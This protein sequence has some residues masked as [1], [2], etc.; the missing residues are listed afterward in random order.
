M[1]PRNAEELE[2][3]PSVVAAR[4]KVHKSFEKLYSFYA[5]KN[6]KTA[7]SSLYEPKASTPAR[8]LDKAK[9]GKDL[10]FKP[11]FNLEDPSDEA[12]LAQASHAVEEAIRDLRLCRDKVQKR[13]SRVQQRSAGH[14][15]ARSARGH[16]QA[17]E[18]PSNIAGF[19]AARAREASA[20]AQDASGPSNAGPS[21]AARLQEAPSGRSEPDSEERAMRDIF[22]KI[23]TVGLRAAVIEAMREI[24]P[25]VNEFDKECLQTVLEVLEVEEE[26]S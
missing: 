25:L 22:K 17:Q 10:D 12:E 20:V 14:P 3:D 23:E 8:L 18:G 11:G 9:N 7:V 21:N 13:L 15:Q 1:P 5:C 19:S 2:N 4:S 16:A 24:V 6:K 26:P